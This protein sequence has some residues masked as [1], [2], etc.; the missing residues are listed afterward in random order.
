MFCSM[1]DL[2]K[3]VPKVTP[4]QLQKEIDY[5]KKWIFESS[6]NLE[7]IY[8]YIYRVARER[9]LNP[10]LVD[11][12]FSKG[13]PKP[14]KSVALPK[15]TSH[16]VFKLP[17][18]ESIKRRK[19]IRRFSKRGL[20]LTQLASLLSYSFGDSIALPGGRDCVE[21]GLWIRN[22]KGLV[23]GFYIYNHR[24]HQLERHQAQMEFDWS[25]DTFENTQVALFLRLIPD[26]VVKVYGKRGWR[27]ALL[28]LGSSWA[29]IYLVNQA[30]GLAC[31]GLG[32]YFDECGL[33]ANENPNTQTIGLIALG[34]PSEK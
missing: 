33:I 2:S 1:R 26:E 21:A 24:K 10:K 14:K 25:P 15:A 22:M 16:K 9:F 12:P 7:N 5:G 3:S 32:N 30:L 18:L 13:R 29:H 23:P 4:R 27:S 20:N 6:L 19:S 34:I 31:C 8:P 17:L 11:S 28:A